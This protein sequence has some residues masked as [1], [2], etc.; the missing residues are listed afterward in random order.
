LKTEWQRNQIVNG[1][2]NAEHWANRHTCNPPL[3][4]TKI[5]KSG[6]ATCFAGFQSANYQLRANSGSQSCRLTRENLTPYVARTPQ[7]R[8]TDRSR[9]TV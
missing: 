9:F 5:D 8:G 4:Q 1:L 2:K 3:Q 6:D 7:T